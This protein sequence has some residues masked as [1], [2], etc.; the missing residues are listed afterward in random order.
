MAFLYSKSFELPGEA[1]VLVEEVNMLL[2]AL[3]AIMEKASGPPVITSE[4][5]LYTKV[6]R[7]LKRCSSELKS[8][9]AKIWD[10]TIVFY[11]HSAYGASANL[12]DYYVFFGKFFSKPQPR[13]TVEKVFWHEVLHLMIDMPK[14]FH[15]G[16][17]NDLIK[18]RIGLPGD[19]NPLG[20]AGWA[21]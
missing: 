1:P 15:H 18:D 14:E 4:G 9:Y 2:E 12:K 7:K 11:E 16:M 10:D 17:I 6:P 13:L 21:C 3:Q 5:R 19:P 20:P 8:K